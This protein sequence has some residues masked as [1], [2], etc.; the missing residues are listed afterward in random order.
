[1]HLLSFFHLEAG[2]PKPKANQQKQEN[3]RGPVVPGYKYLGPLNGLGKGE[4]VNRADMV[5]KEHDKAYNQ[6]LNSCD[7]PRLTYS[8]TGA[9]FQKKLADDNIARWKPWKSCIPGQKTGYRTLC[10]DRKASQD[11]T[12]E[13]ADKRTQKTKTLDPFSAT[14]R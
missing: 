9:E 7:N 2:P 5:A 3:T 14:V 8:H 11:G 13:N 10:S 6:L 4:L 12:S 1:M